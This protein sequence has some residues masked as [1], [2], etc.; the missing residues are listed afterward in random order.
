MCAPRQE[1][2]ASRSSIK[3]IRVAGKA[4]DHTIS[5]GISLGAMGALS[6]LLSTPHCYT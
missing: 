3:C 4:A 5:L 1:T 6:S 2:S